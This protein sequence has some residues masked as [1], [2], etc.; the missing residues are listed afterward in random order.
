[1]LRLLVLLILSPFII[2]G[3]TILV[4]AIIGM[5][6][7]MILKI[8]AIA[9]ILCMLKFVWTYCGNKRQETES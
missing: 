9:L 1:M 7:N 3:A 4:C 6:W 2:L 5:G 8:G